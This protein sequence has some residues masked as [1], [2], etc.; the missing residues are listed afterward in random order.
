MRLAAYLW[1][2]PQNILGWFFSKIWTRWLEL[3]EL[4]T[5]Y[6]KGLPIYIFIVSAYSH[7]R[8]K[9]LSLVSGFSA[10]QYIFLND[11]H[12]VTD[13]RHELGHSAQ[14]LYL[15]PLYLPIVGIPSICWN[16]WDRRFHKRWTPQERVRWYYG[17]FPEN[18]ADRL[19][20]A[21]RKIL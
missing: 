19:G 3:A 18:W 11:R 13:I 6:L 4:R 12:D 1:Q 16:L 5:A 9:L 8:H 20:G 7:R 17:R 21:D 10:G 14:S 2:L 15:G